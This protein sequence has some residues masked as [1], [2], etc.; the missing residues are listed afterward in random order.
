MWGWFG[1]G[2]AAKK[3]APK[4][5]IINLREQLDMLTKREKHLE[6]QIA[7]Q[8]AIAR[9]NV[10]TNKNIARSALK[11]K[12]VNE[13]SLAT[14]QAQITTLEQQIHSIEAATLNYETLRVMKDAG[15]AMKTIQNGMDIDKVEEA[16]EEIRESAAISREM[17][18][19]LTRVH[20]GNEIDED[21]I[22][23]ELEDLEQEQLDN[24]MVR[25]PVAPVTQVGNGPEKGK[26]PAHAAKEEEDEEEEELRKLQAE[27]MMG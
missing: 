14:T 23:K 17:G 10:S 25:A 8:D 12:K 9:K 20:L 26:A 18:E 16:M 2:A 21:E 13:Q 19:A 5:A 24:K 3:N 6:Q 4:N 15:Q 22:L 27:M 11:R 1:G 7:D